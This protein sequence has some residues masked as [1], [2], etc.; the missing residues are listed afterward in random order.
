MQT[1]VRPPGNECS[2]EIGILARRR[3]G[4]QV[5][6]VSDSAIAERL[7]VQTTTRRQHIVMRKQGFLALS[8]R[9]YHLANSVLLVLGISVRPID[10]TIDQMTRKCRN[11]FGFERVFSPEQNRATPIMQVVRSLAYELREKFSY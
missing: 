2:H 8:R 7:L 10:L 5:E 3:E 9:I 6:H 4:N 1:C 11:V